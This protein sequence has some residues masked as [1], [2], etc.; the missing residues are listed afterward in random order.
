MKFNIRLIALLLSLIAILGLFAACTD[1]PAETTP[2]DQTTETP[3]TERTVFDLIVNGESTVKIIRPENLPSTNPQVEAAV[4]I[5]NKI[6][7]V[8]GINLDMAEDWKK[9]TDSYDDST[10]E[11]LVG[12]TAY[13][14]TAQA[15][16]GL[17]YGDFT[18]KAVGNKII[19]FGFTED[20][21]SYA[22]NQFVKI[23]S[24]YAEEGETGY[25]VSIPVE[26]LNI[27]ET[28]GGSS[29]LS[30]LPYYEGSKF[31]STYKSN[32]DCEEVILKGANEENYGA[33]IKKLEES[34]FTN[35]TSNDMNGNLFTT[36]YNSEYTINVG[37]YKAYKE[38]RIVLE[39]YSETTLIGKEEDNKYTAVTTTQLTLIG[40]EYKDSKGEYP[41]NGLCMLYRLADGSFV[42]IDGSFNNS[43]HANNLVS[44]I[45]EQAKDYATGKNIRIAA[46]FV[47]HAHGDHDGLLKGKYSYFNQ[48]TV[49]R[50]IACFMTDE[51][52]AISSSVY[53]GNWSTNEGGSDDSDRAAAAGL[54]ADFI[55]AHVGQK[56]FFA[57]TVFEIL[58]TVESYGPTT[59]NALNTSSLLVR[60]TTTDPATGKST[61]AMVMGDITGPAM[62][63]CNKMYGIW[64]RSQI[65]Q[66]AHHGYTT[67]GN[68]DAM[69]Q[70]Y[71][72]M[73]P[74]IVLWPQGSTAFP[75]YKDKG[76][77][78]VLWDGTNPNYQEMFVAGWNGSTYSVPLPYNGDPA[79]VI[80]NKKTNS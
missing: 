2:E 17:K 54:N 32:L 72:F 46:W 43:I 78:K 29:S 56:F 70:A 44:I 5:R 80:V 60:S 11:I 1:D 26:E 79:S 24:K 36:L 45:R 50:V 37:L 33:Y 58:Y 47:T 57:D 25:N 61:I 7:S 28:H 53:S 6:E 41:G 67:W 19:V 51:E 49:E 59:V 63:V 21:I 34:G 55:V 13:S 65:V 48:F 35:Y 73:S 40:C 68:D 16:E 15:I 42:V 30:A 64:M 75:N 20:A 62:A 27:T 69:K 3:V 66:V 10:V 22:A 8:T 38:C 9:P 77:N 14:Q 12:N 18:V 4:K 74:E 23:F 31:S 76:Y 39:P 52:R 71:K